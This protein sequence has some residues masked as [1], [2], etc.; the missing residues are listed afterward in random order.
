MP[1]QTDRQQEAVSLF[2]LA[3]I[4]PKLPSPPRQHEV[5]RR[6]T[7]MDDAL[8][9][10]DLNRRPVGLHGGDLAA[11]DGSTKW[12][13]TPMDDALRPV[14]L[15]RRPVV[16]HGADIAAVHAESCSPHSNSK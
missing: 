15:D 6:G 4:A 8:R 16:L 1:S 9:P 7:P 14:D 13:G 2:F 5:G 10:V 11:G 3:A 12:R